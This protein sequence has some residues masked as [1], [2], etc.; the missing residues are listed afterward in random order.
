MRSVVKRPV[1]VTIVNSVN[2]TS[3]PIFLAFSD[4]AIVNE[5]T[6]STVNKKGNGLIQLF[7]ERLSYKRGEAYAT[8][9]KVIM[10]NKDF[11]VP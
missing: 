1:R 2:Q 7:R 4:R 10:G 8:M 11:P 5:E 6:N 9:S 3:S